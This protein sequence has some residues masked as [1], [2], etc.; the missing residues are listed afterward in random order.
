MTTKFTL[1]EYIQLAEIEEQIR[2]SHGDDAVIKF[3]DYIHT[4]LKNESGDS[5]EQLLENTRQF[6][7]FRDMN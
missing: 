2:S 5:F 1:H 6:A 4:A 3:L 7:V